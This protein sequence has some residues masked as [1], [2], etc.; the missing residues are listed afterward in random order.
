M[1]R[2]LFLIRL[3]LPDMTLGPHLAGALHQLTPRQSVGPKNNQSLAF[4]E[5]ILDYLKQ[6]IL[7]ERVKNAKV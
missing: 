2:A 3:L 5:K 4:T 1:L 7:L 6:N